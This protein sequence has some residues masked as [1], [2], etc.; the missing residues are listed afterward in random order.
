MDTFVPLV[1]PVPVVPSDTISEKV[2]TGAGLLVGF[3]AQIS[4]KALK[5]LPVSLLVDLVAKDLVAKDRGALRTGYT[6]DEWRYG[7]GRL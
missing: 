3:G 4:K 6:V 7:E 2:A 1:D 5:N